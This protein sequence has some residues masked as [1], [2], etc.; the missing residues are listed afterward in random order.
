MARKTDETSG[1]KSCLGC[2]GGLVGFFLISS[3]IAVNTGWDSYSVSFILFLG[4]IS[5]TLLCGL[6]YRIYCYLSRKPYNAKV[7]HWDDWTIK[8]WSKE[9]T[10]SIS[11]EKIFLF[12]GKKLAGS[13]HQNDSEF[14]SD[15]L[16]K[17]EKGKY[18][19]VKLRKK[20][21]WEDKKIET[22]DSAIDLVQALRHECG[23]HNNKRLDFFRKLLS[24][25]AQNDIG[26]EE[27]TG[28][29]YEFFSERKKIKTEVINIP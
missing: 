4:I 27:I 6:F 18:I 9:S 23:D 8:T 10:T 13:F 26:L 11:N 12:T 7:E 28:S 1:F 16:Y 22:Y 19:H 3:I 5:L 21:I 29:I 2:L 24:T 25:A 20:F 17:T 15:D 14:I